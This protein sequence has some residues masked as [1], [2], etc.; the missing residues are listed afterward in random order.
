MATRLETFLSGWK[1]AETRRGEG[2]WERSDPR[3]PRRQRS[4]FF[5][6]S[7]SPFRLWTWHCGRTAPLAEVG[8]QNILCLEGLEDEEEE[9]DPNG[10][11]A[12]LA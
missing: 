12:P 2:R 5:F 8:Q 4:S 10:S 11:S 6:S 1:E 9:E 3:F 7:V